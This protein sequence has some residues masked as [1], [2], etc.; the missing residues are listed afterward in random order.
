MI[1]NNIPLGITQ[2]YDKTTG[3]TELSWSYLESADIEYFEIQYYDVNKRAWVPFDG[4]N[5]VIKKQK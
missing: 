4:R 5:G 1:P 2:V 3:S